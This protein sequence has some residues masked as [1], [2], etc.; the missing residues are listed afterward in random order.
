MA[1]FVIQRKKKKEIHKEYKKNFHQKTPQAL[2]MQT[3]LGKSFEV[4][5]LD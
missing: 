2:K 3:G 5:P 1:I 4:D